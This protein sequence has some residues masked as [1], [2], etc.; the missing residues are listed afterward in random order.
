MNIIK[1]VLLKT[2]EDARVQT[3]P[4]LKRSLGLLSLLEQMHLFPK[5]INFPAQDTNLLLVRG[6]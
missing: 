1:I 2:M 5:G 3:S 4:S 6:C